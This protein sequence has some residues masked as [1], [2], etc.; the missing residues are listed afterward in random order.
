VRCS[1]ETQVCHGHGK[2]ERL[3]AIVKR[4]SG[5]YGSAFGRGLVLLAGYAVA[6]T[7]TGAEA[8]A[9]PDSR[10]RTAIELMSG[11]AER[12]GI[13]SDRPQQRY[14]WTDAFAVCNLL[15]LRRATGDAQYER[16]ALRLVDDV[17]QVLGRHRS[18]D[19]RRGRLS[20]LGDRE[21]EDHPTRGGLRIGKRLPERGPGEPFDEALEWDRDGQYF[22]YLTK[23]M[24][25]LDLVARSTREARFSRWGRE[26]AARAH[27]AFAYT[28]PLGGRPR[29][30]WKMS[31]DLSRP[32]VPSMGEHDPL[33]GY[34]TFV[35]LQATAGASGS[36]EGPPLD[37]AVADFASMLDPRGWVT[38][39]P[40]GLG[41][42][43]MDAFRAQQLAQEGASIPAD[44]VEQMLEAASTGLSE[45]ES[46]AEL[47]R[48]AATRLAFRELGLAIGLRAAELVK[49]GLDESG[50]RSRA[51]PGARKQ[52]DAVLRHAALRARIESFWLDPDHRKAPSWTEHRDINEVM[53][54]TS[55][56]PEGCLVLPPPR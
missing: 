51:T 48:P 6:A 14:L 27:A 19:S 12:T 13:T 46:E 5:G 9:M 2:V 10:A 31:V 17:H 39:D 45:Y 55:L 28:P 47:G 15:G 21:G 50:E 34:I 26:L 1:V 16:L 40:L 32:L 29:L 49:R 30:Y 22:H 25:A 18:D 33:D 4:V 43:L 35:Q 20:G 38:D 52:L 56:A 3:A 41:G 53:L 7:T 44:F 8:T 54:A 11:F 36:P 23:W 24:H 37:R 42:L